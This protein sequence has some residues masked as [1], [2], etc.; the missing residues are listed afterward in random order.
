MSDHTFL[1]AV[2]VD[3]D[4]RDEARTQAYFALTRALTERSIESWWDAG[5][6][7][8]D[9]NDN[10]AAVFVHRGKACEAA[11]QLYNAGL[12][13]AANLAVG[14]HPAI[15]AIAN[16][17]GGVMLYE[18]ERCDEAADTVHALSIVPCRDL[19]IMLTPAQAE[20]QGQDRH[21]HYWSHDFTQVLEAVGC[22]GCGSTVTLGTYLERG[23]DG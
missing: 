23:L 15:R 7:A 9:G 13:I 10:D 12:T 6:D 2:T 22:A 5:D 11:R 16:D 3:G 14:E 8:T 1:I 18:C 20:E 4:T 21:S 17:Y 19:S